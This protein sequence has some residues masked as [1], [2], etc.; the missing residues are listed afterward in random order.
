M[1]KELIKLPRAT[2][3]FYRYEKDGLVFYEFDA[4][5]SQPPEPMVN[6]IVGISM[7][8]SDNDRLVGIYFHEPIPLYERL[9][10]GIKHEAIELENGDFRII[11][12]KV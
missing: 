1:K 8:Q 3:N 7:L 12:Q 5:E 9:G 10:S 6:T 4:T 2:L 11:F